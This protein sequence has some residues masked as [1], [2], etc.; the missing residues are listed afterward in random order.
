MRTAKQVRTTIKG[1]GTSLKNLDKKVHECAVECLEHA[2]AHGDVTLMD[3]LYDTLGGHNPRSRGY[4]AKGLRV[5]VEKYSP[6]R[7]NGDGKVG[8]M[9]EGSKGYVAYDIEKA[10]A[11]PF[12]TLKEGIEKTAVVYTPEA[13]LKYIEGLQGKIDKQVEEGKLDAAD[14]IKS[15]AII[16]AALAKKPVG[17]EAVQ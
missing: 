1:I 5:W 6:I 3:A 7:W 2:K 11:N 16:Q 15:R 9:N 8:Q 14:A 12:W 13:V 4:R 10:T 17:V